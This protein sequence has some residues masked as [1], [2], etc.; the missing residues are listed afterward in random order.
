MFSRRLRFSLALGS[1]AALFAALVAVN[2]RASWRPVSVDFPTSF[3]STEP[4]YVPVEWRQAQLWVH[5]EPMGALALGITQN[6]PKWVA[7]SAPLG[8]LWKRAHNWNRAPL[9]VF[10][11]S[12]WNSATESVQIDTDPAVS[13]NTGRIQ[14]WHGDKLF[15]VVKERGH[16][17]QSNVMKPGPLNLLSLSPDGKRVAASS[18]LWGYGDHEEDL[19][20]FCALGL[21]VFDT[22]TGKQIAR[23]SAV[24]GAFADVAWSPDSR[25]LAGITL[26]GWV[27]VFDGTTGKLNRKF[28]AHQWFGAQ[29]AWSP[30][31]K[32][33]VTAT[34]PRMALSPTHLEYALK[35]GAGLSMGAGEGT[36]TNGQIGDKNRFTVAQA[37]NGD[38]AWNGRTERL[39]KRFD[40][41]TGTQIGSAVPLQTGAVDLQFSPDGS[42]IALG[43]HEFA[44]ILNAQTL[45]TQ[46][47][48]D[49]PKP[50]IPTS[51]SVPAPV[52]LAWSDDGA[53]LATSTSRGLTLWR[54]R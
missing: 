36:I 35:S 18:H 1:L 39:L 37:P 41:R 47:R 8:A 13:P 30:D 10:T 19:R 17:N 46:R 50:A 16:R 27:F 15:R 38:A 40:A 4:E 12:S 5:R 20:G 3:V 48:L 29:I 22:Q 2:S 11:T 7:P 54:V 9:S 53:T 26:D 49:I 31:G 52:C 51:T 43:E 14:L 21:V 24:E 28:R 34:N 32:T 44:L 6:A 23:Q 25:Q 42:Q 45:A 33:L